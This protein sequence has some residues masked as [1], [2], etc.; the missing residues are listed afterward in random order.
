MLFAELTT[1]SAT[2]R[3][4]TGGH[5]GQ[6][7]WEPSII[8]AP[9]LS[10]GHGNAGGFIRPSWGDITVAPDMFAAADW[11]PP[12]TAAITLWWGEDEAS[13]FQVFAGTA[14]H[15]RTAR[16][17]I[18]Y[19]IYEPEYTQ[20]VL[21]AGQDENTESVDI[22]LGFGPWSHL[23][24][25]R[26][27][28]TAEYRYY[29]SGAQGTVG[30]DWHVYDD[31]V[32]ID[33][34]VTD[35]GDGTFSLS[36]TPVGEV[37]ISYVTPAQS[38]LAD[39]FAWGA[40]RIGL[41]L[42]TSAAASPSP[43]I[44][45]AV[46]AQ[47]LV[48]D[49]LDKAA[50]YHNHVF[51]VDGST[52]YLVDRNLDNGSMAITEW[53]YFDAPTGQPNPI[54]ELRAKWRTRDGVTDSTGSHLQNIEHEVVVTGSDPLGDSID[55]QPYHDTD[56][57]VRQHLATLVSSWQRPTGEIRMPLTANPVPGRLITW[58]DTTQG[59]A[60]AG[61]LRIRRIRYDFD[62]GFV[63]LVGDGGVTSA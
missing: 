55:L 13:R 50:G 46:T 49:L 53:D 35:N 40:A 25:Q 63:T 10:L 32:N 19:T 29:K 52:L 59:R 47:R 7:W 9:Q 62:K 60:I 6:Y 21:D 41:T 17:G 18:V 16:N 43:A 33:T 36:A 57:T 20:T 2:Y 37:T 23:K 14:R 22:P 31:G 1:A 61:W 12:A 3:I 51:F 58:T 56:T 44:S 48:I 5:A 34:N 4:A 8:R 42:D 39:L 38:T 15:R 27:G 11:P 30:T 45:F 28:T 26:T 54:R 24:A